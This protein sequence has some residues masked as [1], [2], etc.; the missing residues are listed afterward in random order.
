MFLLEHKAFLIKNLLEE[1]VKMNLK[2]NI[3]VED[4]VAQMGALKMEIEQDLHAAVANL[5]AVTHAKVLEMA[6][7]DLKTSFQTLSNNLGF[8]EIAPGVWVVSID[9]KAFWIEEGIEAGKD[10]KPDL[11]K[12]A[13]NVSKDGHRYRSIPFDHSK[14]PSK[15]TP[16]A[17]SLVTKIRSELKK[18]D[19]PFKKIE[20]TKEGSPRIG[21]LHSM[22]IAS[23]KPTDRASH[24]ALHGVSIYQ[25]MGKNGNVRRDI[26]TFRTVS[27]GPGS[28]GKWIHPGSQP[29]HYLDKALEWAENEFNTNILP[30]IL[31]KY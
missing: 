12:N 8:D 10:M 1:V 6:S 25:S 21:K 14:S 19:I 18:R 9:E 29:K 7:N 15:L 4:I 26:M 28:E 16:Y 3:N 24:P 20:K 2:F 30:A 17:Q 11:L 22:N 5:A 31:E 13:N 23:E 27:S